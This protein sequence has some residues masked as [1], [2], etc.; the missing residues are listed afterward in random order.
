MVKFYNSDIVKW[1]SRKE[2]KTGY[3]QIVFYAMNNT[4]GNFGFFVILYAIRN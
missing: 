3:S 4:W 2:A 1:A